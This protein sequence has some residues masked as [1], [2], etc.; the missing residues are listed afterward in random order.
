MKRRKERR[1]RKRRKEDEEN[2]RKRR[3]RGGENGRKRKRRKRGE[4]EERKRRRRHII[5]S[6]RKTA[7]KLN[8][9]HSGG[10]GHLINQFERRGP[11]Y[12]L[13]ELSFGPERG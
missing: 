6:R 4:R 13:E 7:E 1:R 2:G 10:F 5:K 9:R 3:G 8:P 12:D 11:S